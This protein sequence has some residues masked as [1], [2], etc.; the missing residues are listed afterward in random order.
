MLAA[1]TH[2]HRRS[3]PVAVVAVAACLVLI[4]GA[5]GPEPDRRDTRLAGLA[6]LIADRTGAASL[7]VGVQ[8]GDAVVSRDVDLP[9]PAT[10]WTSQGHDGVLVATLADGTLRISDP[11]PSDG[12][13]PAW[14]KV[15]ATDPGGDP[16]AGPFWF[17]TWD[18]DGGRFAAI[19]GDLSGSRDGSI[20]LVDPTT[21]AS[22]TIALGRAVLP[23]PPAWLDGDRVAVVGGTAA[24][25]TA[26]IVDTTSGDVTDGPTGARFLATSADGSTVASLDASRRI[27]TIRD[28]ATW[29]GGAD[30]TVGSLEADDEDGQLTSLALDQAGSRLALAWATKDGPLRIDVHERADGWRRVGSQT[31]DDGARGA[32]VGWWR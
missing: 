13:G 2:L 27:V 32:V 15:T 16:P 30:T 7:S 31:I 23:A 9:G 29:L 5:C 12:S 25:P 8:D 26:L 28:S 22:F 24:A 18:P 21:R 3:A 6:L 19:A 4:L 14:H 1:P 20:V 10:T 17:P 11:L